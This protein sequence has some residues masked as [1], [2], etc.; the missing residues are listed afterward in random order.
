VGGNVENERDDCLASNNLV[1]GAP[2]Q[3][4]SNRALPV[5]TPSKWLVV[6]TRYPPN[7]FKSLFAYSLHPALQLGA[8]LDGALASCFCASRPS[9]TV[10]ITANNVP[11]FVVQ[12]NSPRGVTAMRGGTSVPRLDKISRTVEQR[13]NGERVNVGMT[14]CSAASC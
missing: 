11:S 1:D 3:I 9:S 13:S 7:L 5:P 2:L 14:C 8:H 4:Q 6:V 12:R 10:R